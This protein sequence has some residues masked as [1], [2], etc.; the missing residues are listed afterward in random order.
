MKVLIETLGCDKNTVDAEEILAALLDGGAELTVD[1]ADADAAIVNTCC[2]ISDAADESFAV[3]R[4]LCAEKEKRQDLSLIVTGCMAARYPDKIRS[5][6]P[7][8]DAVIAPSDR[9]AFQRLL[10]REEL[11]APE[12]RVPEGIP[13]EMHIRGRVLSTPGPYAY[14]RIADGCSKRC[15]YCV[16]PGIRG[17]YR[18]IP[19]EELA[20]QAASFIENGYRELILIAQETTVY[21]TDRGGE[22]TLHLLLEKLSALPG[23]FYLRLMYCY[24]EE[25]YPALVDVMARGGKVL[26]YL[27]LPI[28]HTDD[29]ILRSMRRK[30]TGDGIRRTVAMLREK[31]P[32]IALRTTLLSGYPGETEEMHKELLHAVRELRFE[33]LGVFSYSR[34]E[35]T[36]AAALPDQVPEDVKRRRREEL[37]LAQQEVSFSYQKAQKGKVL[38]VMTDGFLPDEGVY[39]GRTAADAPEIDGC[40]YFES[41]RP[42]GTGDI[43]SVRI[44]ETGEYDLWGK[45]V[46][47]S[48]KK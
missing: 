31:V 44:R 3:I 43:V 18:S 1:I 26:P 46:W 35:G 15:S 33:R 13:R 34:E 11:P 30:T 2:F 5:D 12:D 24:P 29:R 38:R 47:K 36:A 40:V 19:G 8:V 27:D 16:I 20:A 14:L 21:G 37:M 39:A 45:A 6:F 32:G 7:A 48:A 9:E 42:V 4:D 10:G 22:K 25:I 28:Q 41:D 17:P 23:D